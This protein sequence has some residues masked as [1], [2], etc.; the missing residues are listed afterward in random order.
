MAL[1]LPNRPRSARVLP[2]ARSALLV[3]PISCLAGPLSVASPA[4]LTHLVTDTLR[5]TGLRPSDSAGVTANNHTPQVRL[6]LACLPQGARVYTR[7]T[8]RP[9]V[10]S[11]K[12]CPL[13]APCWVSHTTNTIQYLQRANATAKAKFTLN[14]HVGHRVPVRVGYQAGPWATQVPVVRVGGLRM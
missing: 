8:A 6:P 4:F 9:G 10:P 3:C 12:S 11:G 1:L 2:T 7:G 14:S 13:H 5:C